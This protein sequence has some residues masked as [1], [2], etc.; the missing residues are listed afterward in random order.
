[1]KKQNSNKI[2]K[3]L[4]LFHVT[5]LRKI[6][7]DKSLTNNPVFIEKDRIFPCS[8]SFNIA[9]YLLVWVLLYSKFRSY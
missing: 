6:I 1:M 7:K 5:D 4:I 8:I 3:I 9:K 2:P